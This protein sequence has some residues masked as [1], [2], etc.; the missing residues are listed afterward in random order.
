[1]KNERDDTK[2]V[3]QGC[4]EQI[5]TKRTNDHGY[6]DCVLPMLTLTSVLILVCISCADL[7]RLCNEMR[8]EYVKFSP[9][10]LYKINYAAIIG[11]IS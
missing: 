4:K 11:R 8:R 5:D 7:I 9:N 1:M 2:Y 6:E 3:V 10:T